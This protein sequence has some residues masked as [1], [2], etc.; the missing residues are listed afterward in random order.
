MPPADGDLILKIAQK[1]TQAFDTLFFKHKE[2]VYRFA[3]YLTQ[4]R[5]EADDLFQDTWLRA[6]K[7]LPSS[8][9]IRDFKAW[10]FTI[11]A[12]LHRD[13]LRKKKIRRMFFPQ[14][15]VEVDSQTEPDE[16]P[17][18]TIVPKVEDDSTRFDINLALNQ[19]IKQLPLKQ[20]RVF[21]LK[22]IEG[23]KHSEISEIL[24]VPVGTIK[25]LLHRAVK[26]LQVE[27]ADFKN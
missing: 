19:A 10:I 23:L 11:T 1:D 12:N 24:K 2:S 7:Y 4:N 16:N 27:L 17:K 3:Y 13:E 21:V 25:S 5:N 6:V 18:S 20:R 15:T 14:R 22:E 26:K 9:D 8:Q